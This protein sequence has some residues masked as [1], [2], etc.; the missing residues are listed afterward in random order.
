MVGEYLRSW[1]TDTTRYQV[2]EG[3]FSRYERTSPNHLV[4]FFGRIKLRDL[5]AAHVR[6]SKALSDRRGPEP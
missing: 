5:G 4:P 6:A 3:T 1:L 2:S